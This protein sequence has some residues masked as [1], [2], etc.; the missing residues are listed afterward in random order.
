[1]SCKVKKI[2]E[3]LIHNYDCRPKRIL[4]RLNRRRYR[5]KIDVMPTYEQIANYI[6][7][8]RRAI[9][10]NNDIDKLKSYL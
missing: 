6:N 1:M 9:G 5:R 8:R 3:D 10:D 4:I 7:N 2:I